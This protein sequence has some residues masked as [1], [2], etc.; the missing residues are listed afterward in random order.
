MVSNDS[1]NS[2]TL[3]EHGKVAQSMLKEPWNWVSVIKVGARNSQVCLVKMRFFA[4]LPYCDTWWDLA[5]TFFW[6]FSSSFNVEHLQ[7]VCASLCLDGN[8]HRKMPDLILEVFP[9][10]VFELVCHV[11]YNGYIIS[12]C[13]DIIKQHF[14]CLLSLSQLMKSS[15]KKH[16]ISIQRKQN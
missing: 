9:K 14:V 8:Q 10:A 3:F 7:L 16:K 13:Q 12:A 4:I 1:T 5:A 11:M 6:K 2:E 15:W